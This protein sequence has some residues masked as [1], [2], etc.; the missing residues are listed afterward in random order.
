MAK[1]KGI[2]KI[3]GTVGDLTFYKSKDGYIVKEKSTISAERI[4]SDPKF[5]RTRENGQEFRRAGKAAKVV[6][7]A[8]R[9]AIL[10]AADHRLASRLIKKLMEIVHMDTT[11]GRGDR[12]V[13]DGG[14]GYLKGFDFNA[15]SNLTSVIFAPST[16]TINRSDGELTIAVPAFVPREMISAPEGA[17]HCR[18]IASG[19]AVDFVANTSENDIERSAWLPLNNVLTTPLSLLCEIPTPGVKPLFLAMGIEFAQ[20]VNGV[21]YALNNGAHNAI[22][23]VEADA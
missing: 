17:T 3:H 18:I 1:Q 9:P 7:A 4:A 12:N 14:P 22:S 15:N 5:Q 2:I 23:I 20:D 13:I 8:F 10:G 11:N 21:K 19:A 6:R 16:A